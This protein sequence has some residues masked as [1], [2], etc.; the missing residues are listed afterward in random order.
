MAR[1]KSNTQNAS[2]NQPQ[3]GRAVRPAL[4][5][6]KKILFALV[7]TALFFGL[8]EVGLRVIGV[9]PLAITEDPF[10]G[11]A[12]YFP[13]FVPHSK[14]D[15]TV[16]M[17]TAENKLSGFNYQEFPRRKPNN[18]FRIFS[19]GGSTTYGHPYTDPVSFSGWLRDYLPVADSSR[20]W[21]VINA[22]GISYASYREVLIMQEL[23]GYQ[24]DLFIVY[25]GHN[26]FLE[27]RTYSQ[28]MDR[29]PTITALLS[30]LS[31]TSTYS[32]AKRGY[33]RLAAPA[34]GKSKPGRDLLPAE[35]DEILNHSI[36]PSA[37]TRDDRQRD[38]IIEHF[39]ANLGRMAGIARSAGA[40][41]LFVTPASELRDC[42]PFKSEH[43]A[44]LDESQ[45]RRF[46]DLYKQALQ[47]EQDAKP[48]EALA[49]L[50]EA[51]KI[52]N[53]Y[54][55]L[56]YERGRL[57]YKTGRYEEAKAA[58]IRARDEDVCPLRA[59]SPMIDI[60]RQVAAERKAPLLDFVT[61]IDRLSEHGIPGDDWFL[62]HV[63]LTIEGYRVL[64]LALLDTMKG[65]DVVHPGPGWTPAAIEK[66]KEEV[67]SGV[68]EKDHAH[69]LVILSKV[70]G[71]AGKR[72]EAAKLVAKAAPTLG[73]DPDTLFGMAVRAENL[74]N[75]QEAMQ[76]LD[77]LLK[78][79]PDHAKAHLKMGLIL[80]STGKPE[81]AAEHYR[82]AIRA[83]PD[84]GEALSNLARL[85]ARQ[86]RTDQALA[87]LEEAIRRRPDV[88]RIH[89]NYAL[90]LMNVPGRT[91]DAIAQF[92]EAL[93]L[94]PNFADAHFNLAV[95]LV[96]NDRL[97]EAAAH[98]REALRLRPDLEAAR[99]ALQQIETI[100]KQGGK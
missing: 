9:Q 49:L 15:G 71:W 10:V 76:Y 75:P 63:H 28:V 100:Q 59:T 54:A 18:T 27:R 48:D 70:L 62:D 37:Y 13:L 69:A 4:S 88:A 17:R 16:V 6:S 94:E 72:E 96:K 20:R 26:E 86:G 21:E 55:G 46:D 40:N 3:T 24:P 50:A 41:V 35:V 43:Q 73:D 77:R 25:T 65:D 7:T 14:P 39:R 92:T 5:T 58:F 82:L 83:Q 30:L 57:L 95:L 34:A 87:T 98:F 64:G 80:E 68:N 74:G 32:L 84:F 89:N 45:T 11:F 44:T 33:D 47:K 38:R 19:I 23:A 97:S 22:G 99:K 81:E 2:A 91:S 29:S 78:I 85:L 66:V 51:E 67:L 60:V 90:L 31:R 12:G 52:D 42:A 93:R 1:R 53:R 8:I 79:M 36:G 61:T 56:S